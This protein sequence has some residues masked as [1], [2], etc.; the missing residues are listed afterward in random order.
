MCFCWPWSFSLHGNVMIKKQSHEVGKETIP[1]WASLVLHVPAPICC[2]CRFVQWDAA[3]R[4]SSA[5]H[6]QRI[7]LFYG[8]QVAR[9]FVQLALCRARLFVERAV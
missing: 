4:A 1:W 7:L 2:A 8:D 3:H 9:L 5:T 6:D